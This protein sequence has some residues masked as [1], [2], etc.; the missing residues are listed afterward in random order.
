MHKVTACEISGSVDF[1]SL[2][3]ALRA[4]AYVPPGAF[5]KRDM[6]AASGASEDLT[7]DYLSKLVKAGKLVRGGPRGAYYWPA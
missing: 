2:A 1:E 4:K 5:T 7:K 3:K 6:V